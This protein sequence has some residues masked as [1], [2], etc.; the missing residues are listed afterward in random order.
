MK[1]TEFPT[2]NQKSWFDAPV[3]GFPLQISKMESQAVQANKSE[4]CCVAGSASLSLLSTF[5]SHLHQVSTIFHVQDAGCRGEV[6]HEG[7]ED[8]AHRMLLVLWSSIFD[9]L[10]VFLISLLFFR[11]F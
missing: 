11:L 2:K 7:Q 9:S 10:G 3:E 1:F 5:H 4:G 6:C 8:R